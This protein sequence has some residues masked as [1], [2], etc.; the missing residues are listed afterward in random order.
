MSNLAPPPPPGGIKPAP[1]PANT[2][3]V[4]LSRG[5]VGPTVPRLV[6]YAGEGWGKT[7]FAAHAPGAVVIM[8]REEQGYLTLLGEQRVPERP[9]AVI[10]TW[11]DALSTLRA[12]ADSPPEDMQTLVL[13]A[14]TGF[15]R[16]CHEHVCETDFKGDWGPYGFANYGAGYRVA[17]REWLK[18]FASLE[19]IHS[20]GIA[21]ILLC[22]VEVKRTELPGV[23]PFDS[24][25][26]SIHDRSWSEAARQCDT[27][28]FGNFVPAVNAKKDGDKGQV[29]MTGGRGRRIYTTKTDAYIAKNRYG[30]QPHYDIP[31][32]P[33]ALWA[34][35]AQQITFFK[36]QKG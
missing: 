34:T 22:H 9:R 19:K 3:G 8:S 16:M 36:S 7:T 27:I 4:A 6:L 5:A 28:L 13:D 17:I 15:E 20:K 29:L 32:D 10:N 35:I 31:D 25:K 2:A 21:I 14:L 30:M 11:V 18:M 33:A 26:P 24:Y 23:P 12:L 1:A